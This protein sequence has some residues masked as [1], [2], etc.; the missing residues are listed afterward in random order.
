MRVAY[1]PE[2]KCAMFTRN[3]GFYRKFLSGDQLAE[4]SYRND[5][6]DI[7]VYDPSAIVALIVNMRTVGCD[8][9]A[10]LARELSQ[11]PESE[12]FQN[13]KSLYQEFVKLDRLPSGVASEFERVSV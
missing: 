9:F 12:I 13:F 6:W 8:I 1:V 7:G 3:F 11:N 5:D 4:F 2:T 10:R